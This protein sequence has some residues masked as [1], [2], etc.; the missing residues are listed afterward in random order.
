MVLL[1]A[2]G[3]KQ[4][5]QSPSGCSAFPLNSANWDDSRMAKHRTAPPPQ[6]V[7]LNEEAGWLY[8]W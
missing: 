7:G 3:Y 6:P 8:S 4:G 1:S 2:A 5:N